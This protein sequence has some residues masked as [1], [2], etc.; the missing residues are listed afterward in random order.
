MLL[1]GIDLEDLQIGDIE[2]L[3]DEGVVED[4]DENLVGTAGADTLDG[5]G[6]N[7]T[8]TGLGGDDLLTG[9]V[10][11]DTF[12]FGG[13]TDNDIVTDYELYEDLTVIL[14]TEFLSIAIN[15][16]DVQITHSGGTITYDNL[17]ITTLDEF[18]AFED[19]IN[20]VFVVG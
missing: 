10:G 13:Q 3:L 20:A 9:G 8:I 5:M 2:F 19:S 11:V 15:D 17:S 14:G 18:N 7:D 16:N 1:S 12:V 6:G 4:L